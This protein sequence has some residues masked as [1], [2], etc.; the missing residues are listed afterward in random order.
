MTDYRLKMI[1]RVAVARAK[2]DIGRYVRYGTAGIEEI[3]C[4]LCGRAIRKLVPH[5]SFSEVR[6]INGKRIVVEKL[7]LA[8]LPLYTEVSI[9]FDDG[10]KHVTNLC[11][12]CADG[13]TLADCEFIYCCDMNEWLLDNST[14]SDNFWSQQATRVPVS[15]RAFPPGTIA[16]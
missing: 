13:L 6:E 16:S 5:E 3:D 9:T 12:L 15:F 4:K 7:T 10:S 8:T 1:E 14:A 2:K 11:S